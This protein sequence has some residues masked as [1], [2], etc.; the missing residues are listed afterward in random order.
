MLLFA[1]LDGRLDRVRLRRLI[2]DP[3]QA[4]QILDDLGLSA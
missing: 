2:R 3:K 4:R 1:A